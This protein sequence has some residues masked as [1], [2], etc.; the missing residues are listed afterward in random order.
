[1]SRIAMAHL[2][3]RTLTVFREQGLQEW[4]RAYSVRHREADMSQ[5]LYPV[6]HP[7]PHSVSRVAH[8]QVLAVLLL[9]VAGALVFTV[10]RQAARRAAAEHLVRAAA[11]LAAPDDKLGADE[12]R[13]EVFKKF[14]RSVVRITSLDA[15]P[16]SDDARHERIRRDGS[17]FVWDANS[18]VVT[19]FQRSTAIAPR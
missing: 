14:S 12:A 10:I 2:A 17:G 16:R 18:R 8:P 1:L 19:N 5:S 6:S 9:V 11:G 7:H 4:D 13:S 3:P 15:P